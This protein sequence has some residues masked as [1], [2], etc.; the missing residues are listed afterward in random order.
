MIPFK[1]VAI[2]VC[3]CLASES[4]LSVR[5]GV[6][7]ESAPAR[8]LQLASYNREWAKFKLSVARAQAESGVPLLMP[9]QVLRSHSATV[10]V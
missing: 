8:G 9:L 10:T 4:R 3:Q 7:W 6:A 2:L 5:V 1:F